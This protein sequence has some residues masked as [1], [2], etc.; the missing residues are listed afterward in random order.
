[1]ERLVHMDAYPNADV[2]G[3]ER[4]TSVLSRADYA[5]GGAAPALGARSFADVMG[6]YLAS[7]DAE[8]GQEE[9]DA[10][11]ADILG[12]SLRASEEEDLAEDADEESAGESA[13]ESLTLGEILTFGETESQR[14]PLPGHARVGVAG[15]KMTLADFMEG[16]EIEDADEALGTLEDVDL[17]ETT[18]GDMFYLGDELWS[19][20]DT[21]LV[22]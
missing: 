12:L 8:V 20:G 14:P 6:A 17:S 18:D 4:G 11:L 15:K 3:V 10:T 5:D 16:E 9:D 2:S 21:Q 7:K 19:V 22:A 1:M 13:G